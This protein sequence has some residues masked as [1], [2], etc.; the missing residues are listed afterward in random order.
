MRTQGY[1]SRHIARIRRG[2]SEDS[3]NA[4]AGKAACGTSRK[5]KENVAAHFF[6][7]NYYVLHRHS[8]K[9]L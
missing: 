3:A 8:V 5:S 2:V 7:A 9:K 6:N 4:Y 1:L